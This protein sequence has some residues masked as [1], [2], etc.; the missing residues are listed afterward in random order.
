MGR[1]RCPERDQAKDLYLQS[2]GKLGATAIAQQ[3]NQNPRTVSG[4]KSRDE[5]DDALRLQRENAQTGKRRRGGQKGNRNGVGHGA[6]KGNKNA[7][8]HGAFERFALKYMEAD[9]RAVAEDAEIDTVETE[10]KK[11]LAFLKARELRLTKRI[12]AIREMAAREGARALSGVS[13]TSSQKRM[14]LWDTDESGEY[15]KQSGTGMYDGEWFDETVTSTSSVEDLLNPLE[16]EL[17]RIQ[18]QRVK[19]LTQLD[20]MKTNRERLE[21]ERQ[22]AQGENEQ[23]KL[24]GDWVEALLSLYAEIGKDGGGA[25]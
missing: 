16:A 8:R 17:T 11:T 14:G 1:D 5:W 24:A 23:T 2:D 20:T 12:R 6:P 22:R 13:V 10:L 21:I 4:W 25:E 18:S 7:L 3:L 15:V 19:V 9:E